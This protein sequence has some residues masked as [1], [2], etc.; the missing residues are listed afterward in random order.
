MSSSRLP[1]Y[2]VPY[3]LHVDWCGTIPHI[4]QIPLTQP[5]ETPL[6]TCWL[7]APLLPSLLQVKI[8]ES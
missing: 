4:V 5:T 7:G 8:R 3:I 6:G 1:T 2:Y